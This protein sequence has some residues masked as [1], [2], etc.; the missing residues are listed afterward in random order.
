LGAQFHEGLKLLPELGRAALLE[1][2]HEV[3]AILS[4]KGKDTATAIQAVEGQ[5]EAQLRERGFERIRIG[6]PV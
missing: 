1:G 5:T 2:D 6:K 4:A 3:P